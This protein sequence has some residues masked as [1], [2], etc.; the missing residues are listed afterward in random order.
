[1]NPL[2][3]F[4]TIGLS[5]WGTLMLRVWPK[6]FIWDKISLFWFREFKLSLKLIRIDLYK[7]ILF[8]PSAK[9][10][11]TFKV[12]NFPWCLIMI[13]KGLN[14]QLVSPL[15][16]QSNAAILSF[17]FLS[18]T[19]HWTRLNIESLFPLNGALISETKCSLHLKILMLLL[20]ILSRS[21]LNV[22]ISLKSYLSNAYVILISLFFKILQRIAYTTDKNILFLN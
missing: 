16:S 7:F 8:N 5:A 22:S 17:S 12:L 10:S 14:E 15:N 1:M 19:S 11:H 13:F 18:K 6:I 20:W 21:I 4:W 2:I 9:K 3:I